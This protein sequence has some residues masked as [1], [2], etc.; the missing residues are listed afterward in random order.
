MKQEK[1]DAEY[2]RRL[3][4]DHG[5][6]AITAIPSSRAPSAFDRITG[7][8]PQ[9]SSSAT[10]STQSSASSHSQ[11]TSHLKP[12]P[13]L[14]P[15]DLSGTDMAAYTA[16]PNKGVFRVE[17]EQTLSRSMPGSFISDNSSNT[18]D[19]DIEI[20]DAT[21]FNDNGRYS[22]P[23]SS[24]VTASGPSQTVNLSPSSSSRFQPPG[25]EI[26][27]RN[28]QS[29]TKS[30]LQLAMFGNKHQRVPPW[31]KE[32]S[33]GDSSS[34]TNSSA[35]TYDSLPF[36][37]GKNLNMGGLPGS[38][39]GGSMNNAGSNTLGYTVNNVPTYGYNPTQQAA[40]FQATS[41]IVSLA[42][43]IRKT[44]NQS[45]EDMAGVLDRPIDQ[46]MAGQVDYIMNDPR[47]TNEEIKALLENIRPDLDL[48]AENREGTPDGL[49]YPLVRPLNATYIQS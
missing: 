22:Q 16:N 14:M 8:R 37:A 43:L 10:P 6:H 19:S 25:K 41:S 38:Y 9:P 34:F 12:E 30:A 42:D 39:P 13:K 24:S 46:A 5:S 48:S 4:E 20:I 15:F 33:Q 7:R 35:N 3:Q 47:K 18:D 31:L 1:Q 40:G 2:A 36:G 32:A 23:L 28:G 11:R 21:E 29:N 17:A 45:Y 49:K 26:L 27:G 44:N